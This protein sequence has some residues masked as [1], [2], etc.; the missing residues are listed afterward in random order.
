MEVYNL[1]LD[2]G[3]LGALKYASEIEDK[4]FRLASEIDQIV[5]ELYRI[6]NGSSGFRYAQS[7]MPK[8]NT[9]TPRSMPSAPVQTNEPESIST[10]SFS[11][12][13]RPAGMSAP[14]G[15]G[16]AAGSIGGL[17]LKIKGFIEK[18]RISQSYGQ[19]LIKQL[20]SGAI[21]EGT[22]STLSGL[23]DDALRNP[24]KWTLVNNLVKQHQILH[25]N[26]LN[27][28]QGRWIGD[29]AR[30]VKT[31]LKFEKSRLIL[32]ILEGLT[33]KF[34]SLGGVLQFISRN[35]KF[36][37]A[38][39]IPFDAYDIYTDYERE[40]LSSRV[41]CKIIS[42]ILGLASLFPAFTTIAA[43]LWVI[44]SIGCAFIPQSDKKEDAYKNLTQSEIDKAESTVTLESLPQSDQNLVRGLFNIKS[45]ADLINN[46]RGLR[47]SKKFEK[48]VES[49][50]FIQR[51]LA[52]G[53]GQIVP[54]G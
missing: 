34:P 49:M 43:P 5:S 46:L 13:S 12:D 32:K 42:I 19:R 24:R 4:N 47:D 30:N 18:G 23:V 16:S 25:N 8:F 7:A 14:T 6:A 33:T 48:P 35:A 3:Y 11:P 54:I 9:Y 45:K 39:A 41:I 51:Q 27:L 15:I 50:A 29:S 36:L 2:R 28:Q 38:L 40:G 10:P 21:S 20:L 22:V 17:V 26:R 53:N 1:I 37:G 31:N 52:S 44:S